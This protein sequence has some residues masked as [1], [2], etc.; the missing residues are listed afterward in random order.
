MSRVAPKPQ[1]TP[2]EAR[3]LRQVIEPGHATAIQVALVNIAVKGT[4]LIMYFFVWCLGLWVLRREFN[5]WFDEDVYSQAWPSTAVIVVLLFC[6]AWVLV[7]TV[8]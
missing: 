5:Y 3:K 7:S 8:Q 4:S 2:E 6:T 1:F